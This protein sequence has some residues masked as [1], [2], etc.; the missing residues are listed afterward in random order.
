MTATTGSDLIVVCSLDDVDW[1]RIGKHRGPGLKMKSLAFRDDG[2]GNNLWL[3]L[4][5][6]EDGW[7]SPRHRHNFDQIRYVLDGETG[8]TGWDLHAGE[9]SYFPAG[10]HY[11]PQ[12]QHGSALLFT[13]QFPGA[14]GDHYLTPEELEQTVA[15][16]RAENPQFGKGGKGVDRQGR[17]RDSYEIVWETHQGHPVRY[18]DSEFTSPVLFERADS[19]ADEHIT[20]G[21]VSVVGAVESNGLHVLRVTGTG[22]LRIRP[23]K[24]MATEF[25]IL[26]KGAIALDGQQR[27]ALTVI[28]LLAGAP[29]LD[30]DVIEPATFTVLRLPE[31]AIA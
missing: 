18:P 5:E 16:L 31:L 12:E 30:L 20:G 29:G 14:G 1:Q 4:T 6:L 15:V 13:L 22:P 28:Q 23:E 2:R 9:C 25:W 7:F 8:F 11:G 26:E 21:E 27:R 19:V 10:V 17:D 3:S 24:P